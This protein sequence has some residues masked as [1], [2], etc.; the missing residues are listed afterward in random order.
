MTSNL[1]G[2]LK[3]SRGDLVNIFVNVLLKKTKA[4]SD[5]YL[6]EIILE[7]ITILMHERMTV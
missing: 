4:N 6:I 1:R 2:L 3:S 5:K 7:L